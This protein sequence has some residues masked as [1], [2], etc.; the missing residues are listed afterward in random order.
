MILKKSVSN[1][2]K[3]VCYPQRESFRL[4]RILSSAEQPKKGYTT[5]TQKYAFFLNLYSKTKKRFSFL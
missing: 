3:S 2:F 5:I 4:F 1:P